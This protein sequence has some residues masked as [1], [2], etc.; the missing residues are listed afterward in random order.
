MSMSI[1]ARWRQY[2]GIQRGSIIRVGAGGGSNQFGV[3]VVTGRSSR[4]GS[5]DVSGVAY[6]IHRLRHRYP[7]GTLSPDANGDYTDLMF[8]LA[9]SCNFPSMAARNYTIDGHTVSSRQ[10][11]LPLVTAVY[12]AP[13]DEYGGRKKMA[14]EEAL[15]EEADEDYKMDGSKTAEQILHDLCMM[16]D[17]HYYYDGVNDCIIVEKLAR[18]SASHIVDGNGVY[19]IDARECSDASD[20]IEYEYGDCYNTVHVVGDQT[21]FAPVRRPPWTFSNRYA[22][23]RQGGFYKVSYNAR[24]VKTAASARKI[25]RTILRDYAWGS[26][27]YTITQHDVDGTIIPGSKVAFISDYEGR[28]CEGKPL[29]IQEVEYVF[30]GTIKRRITL[31]APQVQGLGSRVTQAEEIAFPMTSRAMHFASATES[32]T[33]SGGGGGSYKES[34]PTGDSDEGDEGDEGDDTESPWADIED[35]GDSQPEDTYLWK[36]EPVMRNTENEGSS[37]SSLM[38]IESI[39]DDM[40]TCTPIGGSSPVTVHLYPV[41]QRTS[42]SV[43]YPNGQSVSFSSGAENQEREATDTDEDIT[44][45]QRITP[46]YHVGEII[47]ATKPIGS[48]KWYEFGGG[49]SWAVT[50]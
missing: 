13:D 22:V 4:H 5:L 38:K 47:I 18:S 14:T 25:A 29:D 37:L 10:L 49:R 21:D 27:R 45:T 3:F 34:N 28:L 19:T 48:T 39:G 17:S 44:E 12:D 7:E 43:T 40:L 2:G 8:A 42:G 6:P 9:R 20:S 23:K 35:D 50:S 41:L 36:S 16:T 46:M 26:D 33:D 30:D 31:G 24:G 15:T 32:P 1:P 11:I